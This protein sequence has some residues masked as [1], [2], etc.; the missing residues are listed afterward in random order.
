MSWVKTKLRHEGDDFDPTTLHIGNDVVE[1]VGFFIYQGS[2]VT[3]NGSV[4]QE[5]NRICSLG[6]G[7]TYL[8]WKPR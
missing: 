1:F 5:I 2:V 4:T 6:A 8:L 7:I 3:K